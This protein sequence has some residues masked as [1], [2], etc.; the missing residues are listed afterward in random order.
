MDLSNK[1]ALVTGGIRGIGR[2]V[3]LKLASCGANVAVNYIDR[4][5]NNEL[6]NELKNEIEALGVKCILV[7]G[8]ISSF[9]ESEKVFKE[10]VEAFGR[11]DILVN[12]AGI[13]RDGLMMRMKETDFDDVVNVNLKGSWN[14]MKHATRI[15]MKQ[16]Y[17][18]I[19][20]MSS[21]VGVIGNAGQVNYAATK[22]GVIGMTMSLAREVGSRGINV[23]AIAPGFIQTDM[24]D[25]LS[26]EI[27]AG[28][29]KNIPLG[30]LGTVEDVA[31]VVA[32]LASDAAK[33]I[34]GQV[35]SVDGGMAM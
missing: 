6:A 31:N 30:S 22:S 35:I 20:N 23:N 32:F 21:V 12:N 34:T 18:K 3:C 24:T 11:V 28:L 17:G 25:V 16:K 2:G 8:D 1:Y 7:T 15:M 33:Y 29:T 5:N 27:K 14:C 19:I 4:N 10:T 26:D 13:T 9:E